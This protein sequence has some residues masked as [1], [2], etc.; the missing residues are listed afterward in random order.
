MS[1]FFIGTSGWA[2][3]SWRGDFY[4]TGLVHRRELEYLSHRTTSAEINGSFYSLQR[5]TSYAAWRGQTPDDFVF[6][7]KGG[8]FITHLKRLRDVEAA[9]ANFFASGLLALPPQL[10]PILWQ[11]PARQPYDAELIEAFL[12]LLPRDTI[13]AEQLAARHDDKIA[14]SRTLTRAM[15]YA[16]LRHALEARHDSFLQPEVATMLARYGVATVLADS[17]GKWPVI[18]RDTA[19][20]RYVRLHGD[21]ELYTSG[22]GPE[23]LDR[24]A[25]RCRAWSVQGQDVYV[26]FDNDAKGYAP[27]DAVALLARL[28]AGATDSPTPQV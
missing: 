3:P 14:E 27:H 1:S 21:T 17:A 24:W 8:R 7:V 15:A 19:A 20:F 9:L 10:G 4:P 26:Y 23:S 18:D 28:S 11:L 13:E 25:G 2:Y 12:K 5:P 6:A 22:Y 16:P